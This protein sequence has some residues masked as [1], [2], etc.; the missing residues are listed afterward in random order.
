MKTLLALIF[1]ASC[2]PQMLATSQN[3]TVIHRDE[4]TVIVSFPVVVGPHGSN[5]YNRFYDP[6]G[7]YQLGDVW[8]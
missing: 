4:F 5:F 8:P 7:K 1:L 3:G 2:T 6:N